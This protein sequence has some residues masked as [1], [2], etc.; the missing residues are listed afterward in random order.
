MDLLKFFN[1]SYALF[2]SLFPV[3]LHWLVSLIVL[4]SLAIAFWNLIQQHWVFIIIAIL[5]LPFLIPILGSI[6]GA[7]YEFVKILFGQVQTGI[8]KTVK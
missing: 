5:L 7:I 4:I 2:L 8:P 1:D 3:E 6:F